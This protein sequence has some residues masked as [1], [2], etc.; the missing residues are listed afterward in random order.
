[1]TT[2]ARRTDPDTSHDAAKR[3]GASGRRQSNKL[4]LLAAVKTWP[5]R[6]SAEYAALTYLERHEAARRLSD[7]KNDGLVIQGER[8][9]C[10]VQGTSAVT[11]ELSPEPAET[12]TNL[13]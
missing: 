2:L 6:T 13:W 5:K 10:D 7:L 3:H 8:R 12:Q 11:W 4:R 9:T 1:M